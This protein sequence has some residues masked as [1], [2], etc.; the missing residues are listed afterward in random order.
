MI[1]AV[2]KRLAI[3]S[4]RK[5]LGPWLEQNY[6]WRATYSP[7][8]VR[9]GASTLGLATD[10]LCYAYVMFC[11]RSDFDAHHAATGEACDYDAMHFEVSAIESSG[12]AASHGGDSGGF[13]SAGD[14]GDSG[15]DSGGGD[16][17]GGGD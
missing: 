15:G 7:K 16:G 9:S 6:G 5:K 12:S 4:Y 10:P 3:R 11:T 14:S 2:K 17:G 1:Q 13:D 8:Q